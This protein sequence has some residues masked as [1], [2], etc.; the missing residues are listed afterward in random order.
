MRDELDESRGRDMLKRAGVSPTVARA[1]TLR[2]KGRLSLMSLASLKSVTSRARRSLP[3]RALA[4]L[5]PA[6][7]AL[8]ACGEP[9]TVS[10]AGER[11]SAGRAAGP[12]RVQVAIAP[13]ATLV[14]RVGGELVEVGVLTDA[15]QNPEQFQPTARQITELSAADLYLTLEL[16]FE[17]NLT[18]R[19]APPPA[20]PRIVSLVEGLALRTMPGHFHAGEDD[21]TTAPPGAAAQEYAGA[22]D[23]HVWLDPVLTAQMAQRAAEALSLAAPDRAETFSQ[24]AAAARAELE[25]VDAELR[26]LLGRARGRAFMIYHPALGYLAD[27][28]GL[29]QLPIEVQGKE[30][31]AREL[32]RTIERARAESIRTIFIERQFDKRNAMAIAQAIGAAVEEIDPLAPDYMENMRRIG[33]ALAAALKPVE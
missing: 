11:E 3:G 12:I 6:M 16:P 22:A 14:E 33:Q 19:L 21:A 18:E 32:S 9:E 23:P 24:N 20:G 13:I 25:R 15:G 4:V 26:E 28:Y 27:R 1:H 29:R 7:V 10:S 30:P 31:A 8:A 2:K 5:L 17:R